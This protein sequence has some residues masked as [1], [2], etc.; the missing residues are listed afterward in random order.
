MGIIHILFIFRIAS[1]MERDVDDCHLLHCDVIDSV[2]QYFLCLKGNCGGK[3][4]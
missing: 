3:H 2:A 1:P 4:Y